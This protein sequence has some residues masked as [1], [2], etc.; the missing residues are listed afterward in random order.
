MTDP[1]E[2]ADAAYVLGALDP[3]EAA[4]FEA[5]LSGCAACRT[6][7]EEARETIAL[8]GAADAADF[9]GP[10]PADTPMPDTLLPGLLRRAR[11][12]RN[13]RT[14]ITAG[15]A[16]AV[17]ACLVA[18]AF[19]VWPS[20][21]NGPSGPARAAFVALR[22]SPVTA[23]AQLVDKAWGTEIDLRCKYREEVDESH[24]YNLRV[25]DKDGLAH[26]AGSWSLVPG[27]TVT[28]TGGTAVTRDRIAEVQI[29]RTD[30]TPILELTP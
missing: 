1:F 19:L 9:A 10:D 21:D 26:G 14:L 22:P 18:L 11:R 16:A 12:E 2:H 3:H 13:R 5:H 30:G 17:A 7:V 8:L 20:G 27:K 6:R 4:E 15:L 23:S 28:F 24:P 29:T 25:I